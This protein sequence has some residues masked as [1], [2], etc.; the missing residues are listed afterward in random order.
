MRTAPAI[1][2]AAS[3]LVATL[4]ILT[5]A[6]AVSSTTSQ[7]VPAVTGGPYIVSGTVTSTNGPVNNAH[8]WFYTSCE[9]TGFGQEAA[10]EH[11]YDGTYN[12]VL[13]A[14]TYKVQ[15]NPEPGQGA[16][17]GWNNNKT[18]CEQAD[19]ITINANTTLNIT[20]PGGI[21]ITGTI[22]SANGP[23]EGGWLWIYKSCTDPGSAGDHRVLESFYDGEYAATLVAGNYKMRIE[24]WDGSSAADSW[25][26][27]KTTC[28]QADT[29]TINANTTTKNLVAAAGAAVEGTVTVAGNPLESGSIGF[30]KSTQD[31]EDAD[32]YGIV[33]D[34]AYLLVEDGE[35]T[36]SIPY[37]TYKVHIDNDEY[38]TIG[39]YNNKTTCAQADTITI[40]A[41]TTLNINLGENTVNPPG[42]TP[43]ASPP[44]A[45][46]PGGGTQP[47]GT[48]QTPQT[49][50]A[51]TKTL[52][53]GRKTKLPAVTT[54]NNPITWKALT[55]KTCAVTGNKLKAKKK[56]ICKISG[57]AAATTTHL[58]LAETYKIKIK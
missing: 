49:V 7:S 18:T 43:P 6:S 42:P 39:W 20:A 27:N 22:T 58:Q 23:I 16:A 3:A 11:T 21:D 4:L 35:Y 34:A 57:A 25:H 8:I 50:G 10:D 53:R 14:G 28:E 1:R 30:V 37:G 56:G 48:T 41:N 24:P 40:N 47:P 51:V 9:T 33:D 52:K 45:N 26:N 32:E 46:N 2:T 55:R 36:A 44:A 17:Q 31:C 29:I 13:P 12:T 54:Q 15:I 38:D 5:G 19:T